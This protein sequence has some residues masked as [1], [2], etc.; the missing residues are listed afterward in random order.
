MHMHIWDGS[1]RARCAFYVCDRIQRFRGNV[2]SAGSAGH[3]SVA[4]PAGPL[5][6]MAEYP[7]PQLIVHALAPPAGGRGVVVD[8]NAKLRMRVPDLLPRV[9]GGR[10]AADHFVMP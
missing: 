6:L 4:N 5:D 1:V 10:R 8:A 7:D 9:L 2:G 3:A